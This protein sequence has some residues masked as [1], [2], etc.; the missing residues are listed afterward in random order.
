[1]YVAS[2]IRGEVKQQKHNPSH[3]EPLSVLTGF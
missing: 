2:F 3:Q 1:V